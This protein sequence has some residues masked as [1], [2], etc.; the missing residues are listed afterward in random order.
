MFALIATAIERFPPTGAIDA[1]AA[2]PL[3]LHLAA[4]DD[5]DASVELVELYKLRV[6]KEEAAAGACAAVL[7]AALDAAHNV[8][9]ADVA[10]ELMQRDGGGGDTDDCSSA[11]RALQHADLDGGDKVLLLAPSPNI[12]TLD[13][14]LCVRLMRKKLL[15]VPGLRQMELTGLLSQPTIIILLPT[16]LLLPPPPHASFA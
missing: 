10:L 16:P 2:R 14:F 3:L 8:A 7:Q 9:V 6:L 13:P 15:T 1:L 12:L 11:A 5:C 4:D